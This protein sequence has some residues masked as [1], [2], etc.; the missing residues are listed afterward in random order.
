ME[1]ENIVKFLQPVRAYLQEN[2]NRYCDI[3]GHDLYNLKWN[4]RKPLVFTS[5]GEYIGHI[6]L[7]TDGGNIYSKIL[8]FIGVRASWKNVLRKL[9]KEPSIS[10]GYIVLTGCHMLGKYLKA[11]LIQLDSPI[12]AMIH[13]SEKFG[14]VHDEMYVNQEPLIRVPELEFRV[15]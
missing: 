12:G 4:T 8:D 15:M 13:I 14:F 6:W 5:N 10:V 9:Y 2:W 7:L 3:Y 1:D 11:E